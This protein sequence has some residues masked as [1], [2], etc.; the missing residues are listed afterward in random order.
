VINGPVRPAHSAHPLLRCLS[1]YRTMPW[2]FG[3]TFALFVL[4]NGSLTL[5]Q[6][7]IGR[8]VHDVERGAAVV[9]TEAGLDF[10]LALRW[11]SLL[12]GVAVVR[13]VLQ[14]L[15]GVAALVTGQEL[16][17]R[18]RDAIVVQV[19]RLDLGYH[20]RHG[21]GEM[22]ARTTRDADKVRDALISFWRNVIETGLVIAASLGILAYY[23]P[24]LAVA[25]AVLTLV[26][27]AMFLRQADTL[28]VL[29]RAVGDA[30]DSVSQDLVEGVGGVRVIKAFALER[31]RI[32]RFDS[33]IAAFAGHASRAVTYSA[34]H[35]PLPQIVVALGQVWVFGLGTSLVA[36]QRLN[37]G[38]LVASVLAMNTLWFRFEGIGRVI[39]TFADARSSAA[40]IMQFLDAE[41][42]VRPGARTLPDGPLGIRLESVKVVADEDGGSILEDCSFHVRPGEIVALVGATGSGKTTLISLFPRF[43][44]PV[45][46]AVRL[47]SDE[48][49]FHDVRELALGD[50]RRRVHVASQDCFLFSDT[51]A[52]N[53]RLG[54]PGA[55]QGDV[56]EALRLAAAT[57]VLSNL[58][59]GLD[60]RIGDRGVTLSGGQRQRLALARALVSR[61]SILVLDDSTSALDAVT[62]QRVLHNIRAL[63]N[64]AG[65]AITLFVVASKPSTVLFADRILVL[66][67]GR[68]AAQGTH[69]ELKR[70]SATYRELLGIDD[71]D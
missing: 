32:D 5:Y 31:S 1:I 4:V 58:P 26:G 28:V 56:R 6:Y 45:A 21:I 27:V 23:H 11:A 24:L 63:G 52:E 15:S 49:G 43:L 53:V 66:E 22:V 8:A 61:P 47:G 71:G 62:E 34:L 54:A 38:E 40:R 35:I 64:D 50:L 25:P 48:L 29:D 12:V 39:Q 41:P 20:L 7:L 67:K 44:D 9:R 59:E 68:I 33:A 70:R 55:T 36:Q 10:S 60:T 69:D 65:G 3:L 13:A 51:V 37:V 42:V 46:G 14:Y 19:Q 30:Y 18:L 57:D 16:L 2:R 17:F